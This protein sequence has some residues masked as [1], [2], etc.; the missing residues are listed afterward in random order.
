V[1]PK[2]VSLRMDVR[3]SIVNVA[4]CVPSLAGVLFASHILPEYGWLKLLSGFCVGVFAMGLHNLAWAW[5]TVKTE[6]PTNPK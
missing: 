2:Y 4:L 1:I 5:L 3:A 6:I